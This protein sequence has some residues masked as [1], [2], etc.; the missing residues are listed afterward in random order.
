MEATT[1]A[2]RG[3]RHILLIADLSG[4]TGYL[5]AGEVDEAPL[6]AG[7]LVETMLEQL[8]SEFEVAGLEGDAAFVHAPLN[9]LTGEGLLA[10]IARSH[11]AFRQRIVSLR[12]A[13][14][15]QCEA[16]R[17]VPTLELK[18]FVHVGVV[19]RQRILGRDEIAG[20]DVILLHRLLKASEPA[21]NGLERFALLTDAAVEALRIDPGAHGMR[22]VTQTYEHLGEIVG[23][24]GDPETWGDVIDTHADGAA[25][26]EEPAVRIERVVPASI[27]DVWDLLT[28]PELRERWEGID[29]IEEGAGASGRGVGTLS[30]CVA[31]QLST[32][33]EIVEWRP[34]VRFARR[35]RRG[36]ELTTVVH[37]LEPADGGRTRLSVSW[38]PDQGASVQAEE[39]GE[40]WRRL[41][42]LERAA[43]A[44]NG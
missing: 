5:M 12:Q 15:C 16:C 13:T 38:H 44:L 8:S 17:Q 32:I 33:E 6:I 21:R 3:E 28:L 9:A 37:E 34:P 43:S 35:V 1:G 26:R 39:A 25:G 19:I 2:P 4:Y 11:R 42:R 40:H 7:H 36:P 30:R 10:A 41:G 18:F 14:T 20:R 23:W 29:R 31:R 24:T 27:T 22:R